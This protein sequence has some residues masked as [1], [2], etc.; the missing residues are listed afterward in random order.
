MLQ[1]YHELYAHIFCLHNNCA[2]CECQYWRE[3]LDLKVSFSRI[4]LVPLMNHCFK[5]VVFN[6]SLIWDIYRNTHDVKTSTATGNPFLVFNLFL[7]NE[8]N[9]RTHNSFSTQLLGTVVEKHSHCLLL[10]SLSVKSVYMCN[11]FL[12]LSTYLEWFADVMLLFNTS[13]CL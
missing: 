6:W 4:V 1:I 10:L 5:L 8:Q 7:Y 12:S 2:Y 11:F 13:F 3:Y 9:L